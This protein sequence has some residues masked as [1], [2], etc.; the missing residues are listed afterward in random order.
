MKPT[1]FFI[2]KFGDGFY[3]SQFQGV[4]DRVCLSLL[5]TGEGSWVIAARALRVMVYAVRKLPTKSLPLLQM[6]SGVNYR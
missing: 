5:P 4:V 2:K 1:E 3:I 6:R